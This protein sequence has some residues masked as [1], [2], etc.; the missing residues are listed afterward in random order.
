MIIGEF[1]IGFVCGLVVSTAIYLWHLRC[2]KLDT[3]SEIRKINAIWEKYLWG[4]HEKWQTAYRELSE[5]IS[6][7]SDWWKQN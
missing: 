2:F 1:H 4:I 7:S 3:D 5:K 6:D